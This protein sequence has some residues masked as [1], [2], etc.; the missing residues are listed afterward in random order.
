MLNQSISFIDVL[1]RLLTDN[2]SGL[3][4]S[5]LMCV[6]SIIDDVLGRS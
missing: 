4:G 5:E 2:R 6:T 3:Q 1:E